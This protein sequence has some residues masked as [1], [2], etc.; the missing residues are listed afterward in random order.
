MLLKS[1][2]KKMKEM[3]M[4]YFNNFKSKVNEV[5]FSNKQFYEQDYWT[6]RK[7]INVL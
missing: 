2:F 1:K 3:K 5:Y 6:Y 7:H 4:Q